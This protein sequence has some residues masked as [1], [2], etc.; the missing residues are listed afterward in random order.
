MKNLFKFS[1]L[2]AFTMVFAACQEEVAPQTPNGETKTITVTI[3][4]EMTKTTLNTDRTGLVWEVGDKFGYFSN[5]TGAKA[6]ASVENVEGASTYTITVPADATEIYAYYPYYYDNTKVTSVNLGIGSQTQS[7]GGDFNGY[8]Y[9]MVA[10]AAIN[11]NTASLKFTP[12]L[13]SVAFN[14][15]NTAADYAGGE[16]VSNIK[17]I[18]PNVSGR[19]AYDLTAGQFTA[20]P[21]DDN[22]A[23]TLKK[24]VT[25]ASE[26]PADAKMY[27]DQ[28]YLMVHK[29]T[30]TNATLEV[31][32]SINTYTFEG[33]N[34]DCTKDIVSMNLNLSKGTAPEPEI[35]IFK[36]VTDLNRIVSGEYII[37]NGNYYLP[38]T[39][40]SSAPIATDLGSVVFADGVYEGI[41][42]KTAV[43]TFTGTKGAMTIKNADGDYLYTTTENNGVR[44][45]DK[46]A[47]WAF[48]EFKT[49]DFSGFS[50]K[51]SNNRYCAVYN[52]AD[53]RS[54]GSIPHQN[55]K[56]ND[57]VIY[58]YKKHDPNAPVV[59]IISVPEIAIDLP[60]AAV[61]ETTFNVT[62]VDGDVANVTMEKNSEATWL[63]ASFAEGVVTYSATENTDTENA[64][65]AT[66]TF[67]IEGGD[68]VVVAFTQAKA[69]AA[70]SAPEPKKYTFSD[71][72]A[73]TQY[74]EN[75]AHKLDDYLTITTTKCHF[76][77]QLRIYSSS[78]HDGFAIGQ[79]AY[80]IASLI[81]NAGDK[82][83]TLNVYGSEDGETWTLVKGV[84]I[85][86]TSYN[87]YTVDFPQDT[88]YKYFKLDV[89]GTNAVRVKSIEVTYK[90]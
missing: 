9:S 61:E 16:T 82:K 89:S 44:V 39:A 78:A 17:L 25:V 62:V 73:G 18:A 47:T 60:A 74:A 76:T 13:S 27:A 67:S 19:A 42:P 71:Y 37:A 57:G 51:S 64:R 70:G 10:K 87:D 38:S 4:A 23:I 90:N 85:T 1:I 79:S 65:T 6:N 2:A 43:W 80:N 11:E 46:E 59:P 34:L 14:V 75:E 3:D 5:G 77:T 84:S 63:T 7:A 50:M 81:L 32:T 66:L 33:V 12:I 21:S 49:V 29:G 45:G 36:Q 31:T 56:V 88:T 52:E 54:Y 28:I 20:I 22:A 83:D 30:Y 53:W 69:I 24:A 86:S 41:V 26:K 55:Y 15:Y 48:A 58:L 68:D 35:S 8:N 40:T 72:T